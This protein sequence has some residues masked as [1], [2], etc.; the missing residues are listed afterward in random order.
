VKWVDSARVREGVTSGKITLD[1][2]SAGGQAIH[3]GSVKRY[4]TAERDHLTTSDTSTRP[5]MFSLLELTGD[6]TLQS[7]SLAYRVLLKLRR[8]M[9]MRS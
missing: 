6:T 2:F 8:Q 4:N 1:G 5:Y 7:M 3:P 9:T